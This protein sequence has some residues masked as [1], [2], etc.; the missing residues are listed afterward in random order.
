MSEVTLSQLNNGQVVTLKRGQILILSLEEN[1]TTGYRWSKPTLNTQVLQLKT[2]ELKLA[3]NAGIGSGGQRVFTF[4][5]NNLGQVKL[6]LKNFREWTGEQ[7][8]IESFEVTV[9]VI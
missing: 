8:T 6:Q 4:Q 7:S 5:A 2:D 3:N 1:S 9:L